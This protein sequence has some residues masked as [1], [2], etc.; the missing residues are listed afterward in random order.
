M[1]STSPSSNPST[2]DHASSSNPMHTPP[3][4]GVPREMLEAALRVANHRSELIARQ[5]ARASK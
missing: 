1:S 3:N 4:R 2:H 5:L